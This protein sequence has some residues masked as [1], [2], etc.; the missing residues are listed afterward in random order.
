MASSEELANA[1]VG[2]YPAF[3]S[4]G[5]LADLLLGS[6]LLRPYVFGF[7]GLYLVAAIGV[8]GWRRAVVFASLAG[9]FAFAAEFA[10]TRTG[11]PFGL[12]H[13]SGASRG[14]E[15]YLADVPFFDPLSFTFLAYASLGLGRFLLGRCAWRGPG[16]PPDRVA[17][18][19]TAGFLMMWLDLV[20]D[21]L[22]VRGDR[23]F[24]GRIFYYPEPGRYFG[25][26]IA[27]FAGW[28][29]LGA[30]ITWTWL[31]LEPRI[32]GAPPAW[33][34]RLPG[35]QYH[36][37]LLYY[38]VLAFN[39]S[40]TAVVAEPALFWAGVALQLPL[41]LLV[42]S[43]L[44]SPTGATDVGQPAWLRFHGQEQRDHR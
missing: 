40:L 11:I 35:R 23:W 27:N 16:E 37:V 7:L 44:P 31:V 28:A 12:Y 20:I 30:L 18:A 21:P 25:V 6:V 5:E 24:L 42:V 4:M 13:Y 41:A 1:G 26:P 8:W 38:L 33:S 32:P 43:C 3:P 2:G 29:L 19:V 22:A 17:L 36:A 15:L 9:S 39:L 34:A 14:Q 10:S